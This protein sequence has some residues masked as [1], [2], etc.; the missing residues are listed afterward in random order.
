VIRTVFAQS[1]E[2]FGPVAVLVNNAGVAPSAPFARTDL[3]L[4]S[5]TIATD[6]TGPFLCTREVLP[7]MT[8]A[9]WGRVV[10]VAS[11]ASLKGYPYVSAYCAAKHGLLGLTRALALEVAASG[12]T[13]NAVCPGFADTDIVSESAMRVSEKTGR[14]VESVRAQ[15]AANN[16][17]GRLVTPE[18]VAAVVRFLSSSAAAAINGVALPVAGGEVG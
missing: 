12:V 13:V 5:D 18:E 3:A 4:W 10:N 2:A 6:L 16:P 14:D 15:L 11:T 1:V 17:Q 8:R 7:A 9:K